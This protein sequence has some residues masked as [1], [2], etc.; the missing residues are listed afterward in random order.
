MVDDPGA[1]RVG[2]KGAA[3]ALMPDQT[4]G[5]IPYIVV[6]TVKSFRDKGFRSQFIFL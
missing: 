1:V 6:V 4:V 2:V 3:S 5:F